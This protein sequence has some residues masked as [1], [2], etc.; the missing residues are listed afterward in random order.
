[1]TTSAPDRAHSS[2]F[3]SPATTAYD[4]RRPAPLRAAPRRGPSHP[5]LPTRVTTRR[6]ATRRVA[7]ARCSRSSSRSETQL[8]PR[9]ASRR[10][11][12]KRCPIARSSPR[13]TLRDRRRIRY[14]HEPRSQ[15]HLHSRSEGID[16]AADLLTWDEWKRREKAY[17]PRH[18]SASGSPIPAARTLSRS[19]PGPGT[20]SS[21]LTSL[22]ASS[23][24]PC[25]W[26]CQA[27]TPHPT[28]QRNHE[29]RCSSHWRRSRLSESVH[30][31]WFRSISLFG[32][33]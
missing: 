14:R 9:H 11:R 13:R 2:R 17:E 10:A 21:T 18:M 12:G 22:R 23:D 31:S 4:S 7:R 5:Q 24:G 25:L 20:G 26:T 1:M 15:R 30:R 6:I 33:L 19:S 3:A 28:W 29:R 8:H 16:G 32:I 27:R